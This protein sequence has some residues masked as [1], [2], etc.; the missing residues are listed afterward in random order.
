[1]IALEDN[2]R[3]LRDRPPAQAR[4]S[5]GRSAQAWRSAATRPD[6]P[7]AADTTSPIIRHA[8]RLRDLNGPKPNTAHVGLSG[9]RR[10]FEKALQGSS[11]T[12]AAKVNRPK[13]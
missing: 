4:T 13:A 12:R 5:A 3:L 10:P 8:R 2:V 11:K 7:V 9:S 1:V 6:E